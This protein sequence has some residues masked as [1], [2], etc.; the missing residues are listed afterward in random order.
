MPS[1]R[2]AAA[3]P[4]PD[5]QTGDWDLA[6]E[7]AQEA[8]T[9]AVRRWP[10]DGVP[11]RPGA[12]LMTVARNGAIDRLRRGSTDRAKVQD[13]AGM[14]TR[15]GNGHSGVAAW[16]APAAATCAA[17]PWFSSASPGGSGGRLDQFRGCKLAFR[18]ARPCI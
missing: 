14:A 3:S 12:L 4:R 2:S 11:D 1:A 13:L 7:C 8:F 17:R 5:P 15:D 10:R 16:S 18:C 6:G 9:Q